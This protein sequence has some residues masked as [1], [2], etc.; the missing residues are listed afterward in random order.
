MYSNTFAHNVCTFAISTAH[1][2]FCAKRAPL[3]RTEKP[4]TLGGGWK[5]ARGSAVCDRH[6][7]TNKAGEHYRL[8]SRSLA[9]CVLHVCVCVHSSSYCERDR[10]TCDFVLA[11]ALARTSERTR[12]TRA[13]AHSLWRMGRM[14]LSG[15]AR[16]SA[17]V[18][19]F[20]GIGLTT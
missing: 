8:V 15:R 9:A 10:S 18:S 12:R 7:R 17:N 3:S 13:D 4:K 5:R 11:L 6:R 19:G 1:K 16:V 20:R 2:K 14:A